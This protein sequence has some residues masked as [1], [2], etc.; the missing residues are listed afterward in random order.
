MR[1]LFIFL[2]V[3]INIF[4]TSFL[5]CYQKNVKIY[6]CFLFFNELDVL[7]IRLNELYDEVDYFVLVEN[8]L[9]FSGNEKPLYF[10]EN[11]K[12]FSKFS[13]KIIHIISPRV[14][15]DNP[16]YREGQQRNAILLGLKKAKE[17]DVV[18]I[19]DV[20]EIVKKEKIQEIK[21]LISQDQEPIRLN[22]KLYRYFLNRRDM[23]INTW[24]LAVACSYKSAHECSPE[25][26][27]VYLKANYY[28]NDAG[29]HFTSLGWTK[30]NTYKLESWS[31]QERNIERN[32][33]PYELLT[34]ARKGLLVE[35]DKTYPEFILNNI[36][37]Y[38]ELNFIDDNF[39][40][41][42]AIEVFDKRQNKL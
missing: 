7:E 32:K 5:Y 9:T 14:N 11:K 23:E 26:L 16:W 37:Y 21:K 40:I 13:K 19:S 41:D 22:M 30:A 28:L 35:I 12:R 18:I 2:F 17:K 39:P 29:W 33:D 8:P 4:S 20:D 36:D 34:Q 24:S 3:A 6:D 38:K 27:R 42:M 31:H 1:K 10:N 15:T 25:W